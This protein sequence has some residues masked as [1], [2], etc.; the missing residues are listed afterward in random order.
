MGVG[1]YRYQCVGCQTV[2][3]VGMEQQ[4]TSHNWEAPDGVPENWA[5]CEVPG[6]EGERCAACT[7]KVARLQAMA[8]A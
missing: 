7:A 1:I 2:V 4:G 5:L 8:E 3:Q 6:Y